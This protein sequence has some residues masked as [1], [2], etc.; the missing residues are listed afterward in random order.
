[1]SE[2]DELRGWA[3][4]YVLGALEPDERARF[5]A[6]LGSCERCRAETTEL[7]PLPGLLARVDPADLDRPSIDVADAAASRARTEVASLRRSRMRW[8]LLGTAA[9]VVAI[10]T[11]AAATWIDGDDEAAA[12]PLEVESALDLE[13]W[14]AVTERSWGTEV[15]VGCDDIPESDWYSLH[16]FATDGR[17][18]QAAAWGPS[19]EHHLVVSGATSIPLEEL[20]RIVVTDARGRELFVGR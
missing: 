18:E 8:R 12:T 1:M 9:A 15:A 20:D 2:H 16:A 5:E 13:A 7:A 4:A 11:V 19:D 6:H 3:A 14:A 17:S 10:A